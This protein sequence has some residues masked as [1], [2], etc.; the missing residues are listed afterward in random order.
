MWSSWGCI[1]NY[2][3]SGRSEHLTTRI[4]QEMNFRCHRTVQGLNIPANNK[5][6]CWFLILQATNV[7][8]LSK[9]ALQLIWSHLLL[10]LDVDSRESIQSGQR[11]LS[12]HMFLPWFGLCWK[13]PR[14]VKRWGWSRSET[15]W[16]C[17]KPEVPKKEQKFILAADF[18][19][20]RVCAPKML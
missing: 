4:F 15:W 10:T 14:R 16:M 5:P 12:I 1:T 17:V 8:R 6:G 11:R 3:N 9:S 19:N 7:H 18:L 2:V 13:T 20:I